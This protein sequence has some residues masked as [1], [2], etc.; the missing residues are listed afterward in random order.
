MPPRNPA[1]YQAL[2][3]N[4][5]INTHLPL[6]KR[7]AYQIASRLPPNVEIDDLV[8]EG[9]TG[10]LDA[11]KRYEPQPNLNFEV[12]AR[13]R[14]R[15]AIYDACR[16]N[17]ILPRNQR[18]ELGNLEKTTRALE[19]KLGRHPTEIEVADACS[20]S[21]EEYHEIMGTMVNLMPL[22]DLSEEM[23]PADIGSDPLQAASMRQFA[24]RI[25][26]ILEGLPENER[27]V[28]ALHYQEDL[29]YREIAQVMNLT[30]GRISQIHTQGMIRIRAKLKISS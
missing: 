23:L 30:A 1:A 14:I 4:D 25:A 10:L 2:D 20:I 15:A 18:D 3:L 21:L 6:V 27:L 9:L 26:S 13:T 28:M 22:D 7:I 16:R 8:Q 17:D 11:L 12:Y 24:D 5:A 19:Q 29:S